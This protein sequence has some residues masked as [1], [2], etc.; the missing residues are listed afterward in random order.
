M[1]LAQGAKEHA[2]EMPTARVQRGASMPVILAPTEDTPKSL[3]DSQPKSLSSPT[4][5]EASGVLRRQRPKE[6][7]IQVQKTKKRL[8]M[9]RHQTQLGEAGNTSVP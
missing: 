2:S 7:E 6:T 1:P 9:G 4:S 3:R 8:E 5:Q